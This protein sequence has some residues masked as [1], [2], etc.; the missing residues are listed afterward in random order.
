MDFSN[1]GK[2]PTKGKKSIAVHADYV[3]FLTELAKTARFD[4]QA[5]TQLCFKLGMVSEAQ[6]PLPTSGLRFLAAL[7]LEVQPSC[8]RKNGTYSQDA[9]SKWAT[10]D[11]DAGLPRLVIPNAVILGAY[12]QWKAAQIAE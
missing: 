3:P 11:A 8:C 10:P 2:A 7:P 12:D 4:Y 6:L 5:N 1:F 9:R